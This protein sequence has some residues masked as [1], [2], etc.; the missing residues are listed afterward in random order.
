LSI[1]KN[2]TYGICLKSELDAL[3][4]GLK[5]TL[6]AALT[7]T[8]WD[9]LKFSLDGNDV[10]VKG[11]SVNPNPLD[12]AFVSNTE[13]DNSGVKTILHNASWLEAE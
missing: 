7:Q 2:N 9:T 12:V 5:A 1:A 4:P 11:R 6:L 8:S 13:Y 3:A 10:V